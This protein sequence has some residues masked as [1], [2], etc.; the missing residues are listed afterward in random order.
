MI[1]IYNNIYLINYFLIDFN[2]KFIFKHIYLIYYKNQNNL[3]HYT[4]ITNLYYNLLK[5]Y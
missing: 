3:H 4:I 5:M 1:S 2:L